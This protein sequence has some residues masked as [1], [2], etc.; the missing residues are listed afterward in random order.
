MTLDQEKSRLERYL[1]RRY[2]DQPVQSLGSLVALGGGWASDLYTFTLQGARSGGVLATTSVLKMYAPDARGREHATREWRALTGLRAVGHPVP[3]AVLLE[4]DARHLGH[5]FIVMDHVPGYSFWQAIE[6]ADPV[7]RIRLTRSFVAQLVAL[8]ALDPH[9]LEPAADLTDPYSHIE[10]EL[11]KLRRDSA[12]CPDVVPAQVIRWL[13]RR[14]RDV[15]C[16]RPVILHRDYH[17]WNVVVDEA[18]RLWV[19]DWDWSIGDARFDLAWTCTLMRRSGLHTFSS[20]VRDEYVHQSN[21]PLDH[22]AY[23]EVLTTVRWLL[24]VLP[25]AQPDTR[26]D[27]AARANFQAFLVEPVRQA[28]AL[29]QEH[30]GVGLPE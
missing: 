14:R 7:D 18:E 19:V 3:R 29:L 2:P 11:E 12:S 28:Q 21:R 22:L 17:P 15:P 1:A 20:A 13:E 24:N 27:A 23:F 25:S 9:L 5:P 8:H 4:L 16:E 26:S 6:A 30:T 10:R